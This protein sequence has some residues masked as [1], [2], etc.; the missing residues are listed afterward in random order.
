M[1]TRQ[2]SR[3]SIDKPQC[4]RISIDFIEWRDIGAVNLRFVFCPTSWCGRITLIENK[5]LAKR[6]RVE[7]R[8]E[9]STL[10][11]ASFRDSIGSTVRQSADFHS[12]SF[13]LFSLC[14]HMQIYKETKSRAAAA[15]RD[16]QREIDKPSLPRRQQFPLLAAREPRH[17][18][19]KEEPLSLV[20]RVQRCW[21]GFL[22]SQKCTADDT[23][24]QP[25]F[26]Q[27]RIYKS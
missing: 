4:R 7:F 11:N 21:D 15:S 14:T 8:R 19:K 6:T 22:S 20:S 13:C 17:T 25:S 10:D 26:Q 3:K 1:S 23:Q 18:H 27:K 9:P 16:D 24:K 5:G 12:I 2:K